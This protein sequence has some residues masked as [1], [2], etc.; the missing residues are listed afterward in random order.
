[1]LLILFA[2]DFS[3]S[4]GIRVE[5]L[6][7]ALLPKRFHFGSCDVPIRPAFLAD[8]SEVMAEFFDAWTSEELVPVVDL[9]NDKAAPL[10]ARD[11]PQ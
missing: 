4:L 3:V 10:G 1:V 5:E 2:K 6:L 8:G 11:V 9:V 7:A